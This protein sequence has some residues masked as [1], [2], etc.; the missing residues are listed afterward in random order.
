MPNVRTTDEPRVELK[1]RITRNLYDR[2]VQECGLCGCT[3][4]AV[5]TI[6]LAREVARRQGE[7]Q[8]A[9]QVPATVIPEEKEGPYL[10]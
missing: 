6:G 9:A 2:L 4:N 3:Q 7:R 5:V 8:R 10:G 1:I